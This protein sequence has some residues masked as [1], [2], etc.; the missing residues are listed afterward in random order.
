M[1]LCINWSRTADKQGPLSDEPHADRRDK[2][3]HP[4]GSASDSRSS[5]RVALLSVIA[6]IPRRRAR[7]KLSPA[8]H[9]RLYILISWTMR[10]LSALRS[11]ATEN[12]EQ[13][14]LTAAASAAATRQPGDQAPG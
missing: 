3:D 12:A 10:S 8:D 9:E 14:R 2:S 5:R 13:A 7:R 4:S 11:P 6:C 1:F